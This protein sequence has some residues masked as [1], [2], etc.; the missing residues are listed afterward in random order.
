M[1]HAPLPGVSSRGSESSRPVRDPLPNAIRYWELRRIGYNLAL[2]SLVVAWVVLSWPHFR[3]A[4]T[5]ASIA[6]LLVLAMLANLCYCSAYLIDV[7]MQH[8]AFRDVWL[9]RRWVLWLAGTA[10]AVLFACYWIADEIYPF[11]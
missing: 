1:S 2:L 5:I 10:F 8:S 3:P 6:K 11:V 7:P 4:F 9:R